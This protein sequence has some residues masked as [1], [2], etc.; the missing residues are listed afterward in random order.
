M[1]SVEIRSGFFAVGLALHIPEHETLVFSDAHLGYEEALNKDGVLVPRFQYRQIADHLREVLAQTRPKRIV[2]DGDLKHE[3]GSISG[4]EWAEVMRFLDELRRYE[5]ILVKGNHDTIIGPIATKSNVKVVDQYVLGTTL[6]V[7]GDKE[8]KTIDRRLKTGLL[9]PAKERHSAAA[10]VSQTKDLLCE[11]GDKRSS[12]ITENRKLK[13]IVIGHD[14]P[15]VGLTEEGRTERVKCF[16]VGK[17][18][19]YDL[20]V[21]PSLS[22]VTEGVDVLKEALLGPMLQG[23]ISDFTAL[24]FD[25]GR[26]LKFGTIGR[27]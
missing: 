5:V 15:A 6:F 11:L 18:K 20:V 4:Q 1:E 10:S 2:I 9:R 19:G 27:I 26:I 23:D 22:F 16:L 17:W 8:P 14:H 3:F 7:H 24:G 21:L 13:T 12:R 25:G